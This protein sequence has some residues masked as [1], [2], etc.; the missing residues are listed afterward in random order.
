MRTD[1]VETFPPGETGKARDL[2]GEKIGVSGKQH[3]AELA[4]KRQ[5]ST[6]KQNAD[7]S[8][9]ISLTDAGQ[10][11]DLAGEKIGVSGSINLVERAGSRCERS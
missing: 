1:L 8:G 2:A 5:V 9:N 4:K 10:S 7:R 6:L 3:E 11:R